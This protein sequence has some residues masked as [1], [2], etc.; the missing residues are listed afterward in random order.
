[1]GS[2]IARPGRW[3][4]RRV[5]NLLLMAGCA[6]P[7]LAEEISPQLRLRGRIHTGWQ[8]T[9]NESTD[10]W[11]DS[12]YIRRARI[13]GRWTPNDWSKLNLE[14]EFSRDTFRV[15][16]AYAEFRVWQTAD[17]AQELDLTIGQFK[18]PFSRIRLMSPWDLDVPERG[19]MN[20]F[21][22]KGTRF[23]GFGDRDVGLM[24]SGSWLGPR[25]LNQDKLKLQYALGGFNSLPTEAE[26]YR[27]LVGRT[28]LRLFK[29][30]VLAL[31]GSLKF[32]DDQGFRSAFVWGG[33]AKW[34]LG[35]FK[36][37][38]EGA[39]GDNLNSG[40]KLW[41]AH[42]TAAYALSLPPEWLGGFFE[43]PRLTPALMLEAFNPE[44]T[45]LR[46]LDWRLAAALNLD[47]NDQLRLVLGIDKTWE[48]L[49]ASDR[50]GLAN[51]T[52]INL[53]TNL[54]F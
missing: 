5:L 3:R 47:L 40:G 48:N 53:Q 44:A 32:Y 52:R 38:L 12:F 6:A 2:A 9:G 25:W 50:S 45:Q 41:G 31:N 15:R 21:V 22:A 8:L 42:A 28:Q 18:K 27:D 33:D 13:D 20:E 1:M 51:P 11:S 30:L 35:D 4:W 39:H 26:F 43:A 54:A 29:G 14:L 10:T 34:E 49:A 17:Q 37:I 19:L 46:E 36:L 16:D 23:G 24:L 7:A